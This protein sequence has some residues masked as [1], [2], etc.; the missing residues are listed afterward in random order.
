[1]RCRYCH[2]LLTKQNSI[3]DGMGPKCK[4]DHEYLDR[5]QPRLDLERGED[6]DN[7]G[8]TDERK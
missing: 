6:K 1:M 5:L 8:G 7:Q 2:R 3:V 4:K